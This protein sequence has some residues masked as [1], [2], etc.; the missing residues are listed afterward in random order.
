M[1]DFFQIF[2]ISR[3]TEILMDLNLWLGAY[4]QYI[5]WI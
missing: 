1:D 3:S 5:L 4:V 2:F